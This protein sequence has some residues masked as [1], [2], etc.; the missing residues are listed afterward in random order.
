MACEPSTWASVLPDNEESDDGTLIINDVHGNGEIEGTH[1]KSDGA[2]EEDIQNG[3]CIN[4]EIEFDIVGFHYEGK[5]KG[6][7]IKGK[8]K[9]KPHDRKEFNGEEVWIGVKTA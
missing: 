6:R 2:S 4:D 9:S 3:K 8:K 1:R 5:I 7:I